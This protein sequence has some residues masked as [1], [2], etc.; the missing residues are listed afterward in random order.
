[1]D[2]RKT[3]D[4]YGDSRSSEAET[5]DADTRGADDSRSSEC[6]GI[7]NITSPSSCQRS[8][9]H[10]DSRETNSR[11]PADGN[12]SEENSDDLKLQ[13]VNKYF[14]QST[15]D[16]KSSRI[17]D[18]NKYLHIVASVAWEITNKSAL[19]DSLEGIYTLSEGLVVGVGEFVLG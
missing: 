5:C 14:P 13:E 18:S 19:V 4:S 10:L 8:G 9:I 6:S 15:K 2:G 11:S 1:M 3:S 7:D 16:E 17:L 12:Q